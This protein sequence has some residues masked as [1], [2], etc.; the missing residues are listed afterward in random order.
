MVWY[1][2][3]VGLGLFVAILFALLV[4]LT[5]KGDAMSGGSAVRT[6]FKGK[7]SFDDI[8]SRLTLYLGVGF[9]A[10]MLLIDVVGNRVLTSTG[11]AKESAGTNQAQPAQ[12][13]PP[14][15]APV[16][17]PPATNAPATNTP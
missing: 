5:G 11:Q 13:Q 1:N 7:A 14:A 17:T 10:L 16:A 6:T 15:N 4:F 9:M 12:N 3:L 8:I 2:I